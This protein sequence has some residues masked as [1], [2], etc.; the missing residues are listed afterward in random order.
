MRIKEVTVHDDVSFLA[1]I[2]ATIR[3]PSNVR[4]IC[5]DIAGPAFFPG[6]TG[7]VKDGLAARNIKRGGVL[8]LGHNFGNEKDYEAVKRHGSEFDTNATWRQLRPLL[9]D[10]GIAIDDCFFSNVL[11]GAMNSETSIGSIDEHRDALFR[12]DCATLLKATIDLQLPTVIVVLGLFALRFVGEK[13]EPLSSWRK[14]ASYRAVDTSI[15]GPIREM[16]YGGRRVLAV[17]LVHPSFGHLNR[18]SRKFSGHQG[19][20]AEVAMLRIALARAR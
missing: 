2:A 12:E 11:M 16:S 3:Y 1:E 13:L 14:I 10:G 19:K 7:V 8:V 5:A 17:A 9:S 20:D 4:P 6:G 18:K 15:D